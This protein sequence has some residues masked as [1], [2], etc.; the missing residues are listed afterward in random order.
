MLQVLI[1]AG[2]KI[3]VSEGYPLVNLTPPGPDDD[4][5]ESPGPAALPGGSDFIQ[6]PGGRL[7]GSKGRPGKKEGG[8]GEDKSAAKFMAAGMDKAQ[9]VYWAKRIVEGGL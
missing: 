4:I 8:E 2:F 5:I 9:A 3:K 7:Q 1:T 6:G